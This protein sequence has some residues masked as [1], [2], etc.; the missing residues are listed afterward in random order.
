MV[1]PQRL[2]V[3]TKH[4]TLFDVKEREIT[5][6]ERRRRRRKTLRPDNNFFKSQAK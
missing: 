5:E 6:E 2:L 4:R 3:G 1:P